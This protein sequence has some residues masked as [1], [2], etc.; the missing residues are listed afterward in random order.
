[1]GRS[2]WFP[3]TRASRCSVR[4]PFLPAEMYS[5]VAAVGS[6]DWPLDSITFVKINIQPSSFHQF[7]LLK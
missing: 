3:W 1:L 5:W 4:H 2:L 7:G 6:L